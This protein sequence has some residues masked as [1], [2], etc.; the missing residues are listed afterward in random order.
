MLPI[1]VLLCA[2]HPRC[3]FTY[4]TF[5]VLTIIPEGGRWALFIHILQL[6][7]LS[8]GDV[9]EFAQGKS[10]WDLELGFIRM[11]G[12]LCSCSLRLCHPRDC[13]GPPSDCK[14]LCWLAVG[15][16]RQR[17][18]FETSGRQTCEKFMWTD[19]RVRLMLEESPNLRAS[20]LF[21]FPYL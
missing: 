12:S 20:G 8:R 11:L 2:K 13:K 21:S 10:L 15:R 16:G 4:F 18:V 3:S 17:V 9:K 1:D 14:S 5:F 6:G 7:K 19:S